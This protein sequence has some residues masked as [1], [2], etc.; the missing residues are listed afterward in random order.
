MEID[1]SKIQDDGYLERLL[2]EEEEKRVEK[3]Q[4]NR[5]WNFEEL[6][7]KYDGGDIKE[8][9]QELRKDFNNFVNVG[10][11][12]S[13]L[14]G[15][16]LV[17]ALSPSFP[18]K[19]DDQKY[20]AYFLDNLDRDI[21]DWVLDLDL[22]KTVFYV[23]SKSGETVETLYNFLAIREALIEEG[24]DWKNHIIVATK[25][26]DLE[27]W[28]EGSLE[29][30]EF[31]EVPGRYSA[32]SIIGLLPVSFVGADPIKILDGAKKAEKK[33]SYEDIKRN[34][35]YLLA[36]VYYEL[37]K[38]ISVIMPYTERLNSFTEWYA[39]L[40][41]ESLGKEGKGIT[42]VKALGTRDQHSLLQLLVDGPMDK[43]VTLI[44]ADLKK[45]E[46]QIQNIPEDDY[47]LEG[48]TLKEVKEAEFYGT[49]DS[50]IR[51]DVPSIQINMTLNEEDMGELLFTYKIAIAATG[52]LYN[53]NPFNQP[54]VE[55]GKNK[56]YS[57]L[58]K[59]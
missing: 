50:F 34:P 15:K 26:G 25:N 39:Q 37:E 8:L 13:A 59:K 2:N 6:L 57:I 12:G 22:E 1:L 4:D 48:K 31:P 43:L 30:V 18:Y 20:T 33:C 24:L 3:I 5:P 51:S 28:V 42:P 36:S 38:P 23:V 21:L 19:K 29:L 56:V 16:A 41:A 45:N 10:I 49:Q 14:G 58:G 46:K 40:C 55:V 52:S 7:D 9:S 35:G 32:L 11:G 27:N 53:I 54:G 47:Y 17:N 44:N